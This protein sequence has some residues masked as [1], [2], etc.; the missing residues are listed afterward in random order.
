MATRVIKADRNPGAEGP[1]LFNFDDLTQQ[2]TRYL[3]DIKQRGD[4]LLE[5]AHAC[6][7]D[8]REEARQAGYAEGCRQAAEAIE[9]QIEQRAREV[10]EQQLLT[11]LNKAV[12]QL[13]ASRAAWLRSW[14]TGAI[15]LAIAIA[16]RLVRRKVAE[17]RE[18]TCELVAEALEL[19]A[20]ATEVTLRMNPDDLQ[21]LGNRLDELFK[22][23][24]TASPLQVVADPTIETG[25]C[26]VQTT[27]GT[28]DGRLESRLQRIEEELLG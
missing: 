23:V 6:S 13:A 1:I 9:E 22:Q 21:T 8:I 25:D 20:G 16:K 18:V 15:R 5:Q 7:A 10:A 17:D 26:I 12:R 2:A 19:F 11:S 24:G 14:E 3:N 4:A 28:A 27:E